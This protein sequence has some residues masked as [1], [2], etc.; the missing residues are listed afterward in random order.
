MDHLTTSDL[1]SLIEVEA[2]WC[3]SI[4]LPTVRAGAEVQQNPIRFKNLLRSAEDQLTKLGLRTSDI[5]KLLQPA[6][7]LLGDPDFWRQTGDGLAVYVAPGQTHTFRL[8]LS[9]EERVSV[10][11]RFHVKPLF[12][13]LSGDGRFYVLA[14]SQKSVRLLEGTRDSVSEVDLEGVPESLAEALGTDQTVR[15]SEFR[16]VGSGAPGG[17][18]QGPVYGGHGVG[19]EDAKQDILRYFHRVDRG[20]REL[21]A[22]KQIPL[23]LAGVDYLLPIYREANT[24]KHLIDAGITGNPDALSAKELHAKA[25]ELVKPI[26]SKAQAEQ[27]ALYQELAARADPR[28]SNTLKDIVVGAHGGRVA[29]LFAEMGARTWGRFN[30]GDGTV[31][32]HPE[33]QPGDQDLLDLAVSFTFTNSGQVYVVEKGA[34]PGGKTIAAI[35]RY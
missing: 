32:V 22:G 13:L 21:I 16:A 4:L 14:L 11:P 34:V 5:A 27:A 2:E 15:Q 12:P 9:F 35:F 29:T 31:H 26:F 30:A 19:D 28:A 33:M 17:G 10:K 7:A 24:H 20:L 3:V 8:P 25:W 23:V 6:T 1:N 18:S